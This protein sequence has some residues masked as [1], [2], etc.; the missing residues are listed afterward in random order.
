[1]EQGTAYLLTQG[2]LGLG[3]LVLGFVV[4]KLYNSRE[5]D[6]KEWREEI[7]QLNLLLL[8]SSIDSRK[9]VTEL[10]QGISRNMELLSAK[11]QISKEHEEK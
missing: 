10:T 9:E 11:I 3:V 2:S 6:R 8:Q 7:K 4:N 5:T 1:M